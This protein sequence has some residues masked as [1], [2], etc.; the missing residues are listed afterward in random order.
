M[1]LSVGQQPATPLTFAIATA[2]DGRAIASVRN[3]A[4]DHLTRTYGNG[5]WSWLT[6]ER[7]VLRDLNS[8]RSC[9]VLLARDGNDV[10][11]TLLLQTKK[12]WAIDAAYFTSVRRPLY[13]LSMAVHPD[14]QRQHVGRML[15]KEAEARA[16][17]WPAQAIR[18]DAFD[19][20]AGAGAF[21]TK[22]GYREVGRVVYH[23]TPLIYFAFVL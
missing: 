15:L 4:A 16:R 22:C 3:A 8:P 13:L 1:S 19:A 12:P 14:Y 21:Y 6:S 20:P 5:H 2:A 11:A 18:L 23:G 9:R 10:I 7:A 17:E